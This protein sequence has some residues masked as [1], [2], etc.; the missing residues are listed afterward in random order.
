MG[1]VP[2]TAT[3]IAINITVTAAG[4][5]GHLR[6]GVS[7]PGVVY[8]TVNYPAGLSRSNNAILGLSPSGNLDALAVQ[9]AGTTV[10]VIIDVSGYFE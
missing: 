2:D 10:H 3:A 4:S 1:G 5:S 7:D 8:S 6:L 9:S